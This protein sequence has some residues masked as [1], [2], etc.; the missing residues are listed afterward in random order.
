[1]KA[2]ILLILLWPSL[3]WLEQQRYR[4]LEKLWVENPAAC[5]SYAEKLS[6]NN[7]SSATPYYYLGKMA[8]S[9]YNS[10]TRPAIK[11]RHLR[12]TVQSWQQMNS[13]RNTV[14]NENHIEELRT[15]IEEALKNSSSFSTDDY[16][17][18]VSIYN[19]AQKAGFK[20]PERTT[21]PKEMPVVESDE[22]AESEITVDASYV[23]V[24]NALFRMINEERRKAGLGTLQWD[25]DLARA[26]FYHAKDMATED[27][28]DHDS[29]NRI[30]GQLQE[31]E[32]TFVRI[33]KFY[34]NGFAHSENI[35]AGNS[36]PEMTYQQWFN[37][38]GHYRNMFKSESTHAAVGVFYDPNSTFGWYW[39]F[40][41]A[42]GKAD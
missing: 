9:K 18:L 20:V 29:K 22:A 11:I 4:R 5:A 23:Q 28:F 7:Q 35:A 42:R 38:P 12:Q 25:K 17:A 8:V 30:N 36:S 21:I 40:C 16:P 1:M 6:K 2:F 13:R 41:G 32:E 15:S 10:E 27:Y 26:A 34:K 24:A 19:K 3:P 39:V 33:G 14:I 37:S 31:A